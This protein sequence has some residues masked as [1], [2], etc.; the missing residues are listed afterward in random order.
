MI[1]CVNA[2]SGLLPFLH[3]C[4]RVHLH[5]SDV[6]QRPKRA[7]SI[8]TISQEVKDFFEKRCQRPKRASSIST[9]YKAGRLAQEIQCV[10]ALNGLLP[11]LP[12]LRKDEVR[13]LC[14]C[15]RPKRASSISTQKGVEN[16]E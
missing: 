8:S 16:N 15:Q 5:L 11:F 12:W 14:W 10:N 13:V 3:P 4:G 2:L 9:G 6:C 1:W 7:S